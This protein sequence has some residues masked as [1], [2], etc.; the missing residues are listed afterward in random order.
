M[1]RSIMCRRFKYQ[2][3]SFL[4]IAFTLCATACSSVGAESKYFG[5][6]EP[7]PGQVLRYHTGA[8]PQSL[9]PQ[10]MTGQPESR[11]AVALYD[12]LVEYDEKGINPIPSLAESWQ[13]NANGTVWVFKLR[14]DAKWSDGAP[15]TAHD[16]VYSWRRAL[17]PDFA[18]QYASMGYVVN[19]GQAY[20]E[21][22]AFVRDVS[23]GKFATAED[24]KQAKAGGAI[25][26]NG[27]LPLRFSKNIQRDTNEKTDTDFVSSSDFYFVPA[28]EAER[29]KL[30]DGDAAKNKTGDKDLA[31]FIEGKEIVPVTADDLGVR[32]LD[33]YTF[34][35]TLKEP[36]GYFLKAILHQFF[37]PVPKQ[38]IEKWGDK[39]WTKPGNIVTSGAFKLTEWT[40]YDRIVVE[41]NPLFWDNANTRL[42]KIVFPSIEELNTAMNLYKAGQI[43]ATQSLTPPPAWRNYLKATKLDYLS[44]PYLSI[45]Y[46]WFNVGVKPLDDVRVRRAMSMA[47]N[48]Q[49][50]ADRAPGQLPLTGF[51]PPMEG[52]T[53]AKGIDY[54]PDAA[55]KLLAEAGYPEGRGFPKIEIVYN[56]SESN[57]QLMELV[58]AMLKRELNIPVELTN[59]EWRVYLDNTGKVKYNGLARQGWIG[60]YVD[61]NTFLELLTST[62]ANNKSGWKD[63]KYD[64]LLAEANSTVDQQERAAKLQKT[65]S[66]LL[67]QQPMIP[68]I[69]KALALMRKPYV[70]NLD[71]NLLDQYNWRRV[72][73]DHNWQADAAAK[74]N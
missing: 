49:I 11:I 66:Y 42:D 40:P 52:Y 69:V 61:P 9:D 20:N 55:R 41:R 14:R 31:R 2:H 3:R 65:E 51:T 73:I 36:T 57:K 63:L 1:Y 24:F 53:G 48:R 44:G 8:E 71:G 54:N 46:V 72:Y 34:E 10:Y 62:S 30:I 13:P 6:T 16:F 27:D 35:V 26:F 22:S 68:L 28:D 39:L 58:Q 18:A 21:G 43:D 15:I 47:I 38:A 29:K 12:G 67:E 70:K 32:A 23:T 5:S 7:P 50:L 74:A 56:T 4:L 17:S 25:S 45:E 64:Q 33:D 19:F 37:R 60:D 59:Q